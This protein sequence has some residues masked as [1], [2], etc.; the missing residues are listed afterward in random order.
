MKKLFLWLKGN[1]GLIAVPI[2]VVVLGYMYGSVLNLFD[3]IYSRNVHAASGWWHLAGW[4]LTA[5]AAYEVY[6]MITKI[7]TTPGMVAIGVLLALSFC[8]FA[9]FTFTIG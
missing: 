6:C 1:G 3:N 5:G 7:A 8:A 9:G 2:I 4:V